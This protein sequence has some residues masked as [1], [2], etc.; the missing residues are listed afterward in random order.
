[1]Y[2]YD[3]ELKENIKRNEKYIQEFENWLKENGLGKETIRK[4]LNNVDLYINKY[5]NYYEIIKAEDGIDCVASFLGDWFIEKCLWASKKTLKETVASIKKFYQYMSEN[6]YVS[7][8]KY[9]D[10]CSSIKENMNKF[11]EQID[12]CSEEIYY[13]IS[14]N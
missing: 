1:M 9:E 13:D 14:F 8:V 12:A 4:H 10:M 7:I 11:L 5:L 2:N 3:K 6:N